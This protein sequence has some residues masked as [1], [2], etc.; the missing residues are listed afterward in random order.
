MAQEAQQRI[1][2]LDVI[3]SGYQQ[4]VDAYQNLYKRYHDRHLLSWY[5]E[6]NL[7]K[8]GELQAE[9]L[10]KKK[11]LLPSIGKMLKCSQLKTVHQ[12]LMYHYSRTNGFSEN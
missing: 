5:Y 12:I 10:K 3:R 6:S 7:M 1:H 8:L 4:I 9:S 11:Q 2:E